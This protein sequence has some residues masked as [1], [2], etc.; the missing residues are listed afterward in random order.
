MLTFTAN[1]TGDYPIVC[2]ELCGPYHGGMRSHVVVD[3]PES[4]ATWV[5]TNTPATLS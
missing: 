1:R 4:F 5:E 3:E 2:A